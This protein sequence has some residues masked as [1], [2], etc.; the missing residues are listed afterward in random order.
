MEKKIGFH[1]FQDLNHYQS[2][3]LALWQPELESLQAG[4]LVLKASPNYAIPEEF[5]TGLLDSDVQPIIHFDIP[6]NS[7]YRPEDLRILLSSYARW[8]VKYVIFFDRPNMKSS[9]LHDTW[10]QGDL[11]ERFLD[12]YLPFVRAAEQNGLTP[13]FPPLQ[14][15]GDYWDLSFLKK[16]L[17]LV[18]Q[19]R[20]LD[21]VSNLHI[22]VSSQTFN[23]PLSWGAGGKRNWKV[24]RPYSKSEIGEED[25][26][27]FNTWQWYTDLVNS[28]LGIEPKLFLFY[29]GSADIKQSVLDPKV[30]FEELID[31]AMKPS[32]EAGRA[33]EQKNN[34]LACLFWILST[35]EPNEDGQTAFFDITGEVKVPEIK[36][37]KEKLENTR[38]QN[39]EYVV[40]DRLAE[41][42]YPIDHYLLLP[43]Y[44]WGIP[45]N[46]LDRIRPIM[47]DSRPTIGFSLI[48]A[49]NARKV[50]VWNEN[51][52]FSVKDIDILR[53]AGCLIDEQ[54]VNSIGIPA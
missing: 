46:T 26:L 5:I 25:H 1:Y 3:D 42:I 10:S 32:E 6:V 19:R 11:V 13:I 23:H 28:I 48:E 2:R 24:P 39:L 18:K 20:S 27:G 47:R 44:E 9:W 43:S 14:P 4:W 15:G 38:K 33:A 41:W 36:S 22:A 54:I 8:G 31:F 17:N 51:G 16:V 49:T 34:I 37:Y 45:E 12:R 50:T 35:S 52:A 29:F 53:E 7:D 30:S 21:F 40:S